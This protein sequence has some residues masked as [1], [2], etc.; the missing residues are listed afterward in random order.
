MDEMTLKV[1]ARGMLLGL[2]CCDALGT[3]NEFLSREEA[4]SLNGIIGGGPFNLE[5]GNWTDDTSM[6]LCLADALL[7][8]KRYDSEA[9]MNAYAD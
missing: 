7:A 2:A 8:E 1:R 4:L 3:T 6:A 5:A 9:V